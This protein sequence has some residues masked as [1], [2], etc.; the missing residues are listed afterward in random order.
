MCNAYKCLLAIDCG[1]CYADNCNADNWNPDKWKANTCNADKCNACYCNAYYCNV[2][3]C[4]ADKWNA[5][6]C[7]ADNIDRNSKFCYAGRISP[8]VIEVTTSGPSGEVKNRVNAL[9]I[10]NQ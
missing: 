7:N 1:S 9:N 4:Y 5:D 8:K 10:R 6:K 2:Y 3:E